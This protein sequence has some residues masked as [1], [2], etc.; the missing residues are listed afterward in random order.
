MTEM[1]PIPSVEPR[2]PP[3]RHTQLL[4]KAA[5]PSIPFTESR[6]VILCIFAPQPAYTPA[7]CEATAHCDIRTSQ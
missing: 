6:R 2:F 7:Q 5:A 3:R 1:L 4:R